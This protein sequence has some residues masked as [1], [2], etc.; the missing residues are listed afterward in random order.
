MVMD[1]G[2]AELASQTGVVDERSIAGDS[3][4]IIDAKATVVEDKAPAPKDHA[5]NMGTLMTWVQSHD[6]EYNL[7]W[8]YKNQSFSEL[9]LMPWTDEGLKKRKDAVAE[10]RQLTGWLD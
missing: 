4:K 2:V 9:E 8:F 7:T 5:K 10:I 1:Q 6:K 3:S